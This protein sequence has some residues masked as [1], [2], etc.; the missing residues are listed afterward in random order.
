MFKIQALKSLIF[1]CI[2]LFIR[3]LTN[4]YQHFIRVCRK[5]WMNLVE[6]HIGLL[7]NRTFNIY[8]CFSFRVPSRIWKNIEILCRC[9]LQKFLKCGHT[10][11]S[12][13]KV[14]VQEE[15]GVYCGYKLHAW[16]S[17]V[18]KLVAF[19]HDFAPAYFTKTVPD[20]MYILSLNGGG[21]GEGGRRCS[22]EMA[23]N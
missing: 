4:L 22:K 15:G 3:I 10:D 14:C 18:S 5:M 20:Y 8:E 1:I 23:G 6:W 19:L 2:S 11:R 12:E 7:W 9:V 17:V 21:R 16:T 13:L